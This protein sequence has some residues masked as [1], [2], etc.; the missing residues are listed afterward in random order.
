MQISIYEKRHVLHN[1]QTA[2]LL[3]ALALL[4]AVGVLFSCWR[5]SDLQA[6]KLSGQ[7]LR[8]HVLADSDSAE[9]QQLKLELRSYLLD[10]LAP[11]LSACSDAA[12][13]RRTDRMPF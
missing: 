11:S 3:A 8:F 10:R 6:R 2:L 4:L 9:D 12:T 5:L 1:L 7:V 13:R